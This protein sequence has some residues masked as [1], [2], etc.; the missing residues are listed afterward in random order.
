MLLKD[1][2]EQNHIC[3]AQSFTSWEDAVWAACKPILDDDTIQPTY[4]QTMIDSVKKFGP[5]IVFAPHIAM[6][7]AQQGAA[8]VNRTAISFMKVETPVV[9]EAGNP[10]KD[11][12]LFFV[13]ASQNP[14]QHM[15]N[16]E[17]L[18]MALMLP[19]FTEKML[20]VTCVE[21]LLALDE[22]YSAVCV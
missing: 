11:A 16:M 2:V 14:D 13:L 7:H 9:F 1:L 10:E 6:P 15:A 12:E 17:K 18:A 22:A 21:D 19:D 4:V 20:T 3:F 8:G 5:Y